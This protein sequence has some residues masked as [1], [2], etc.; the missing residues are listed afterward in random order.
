MDGQADSTSFVCD[1]TGNGLAN[2][3]DGVGAEVV[4]ALPL[5][6]LDRVQQADVT[7]RDQILQQ[8][9]AVCVAARHADHKT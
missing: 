4:T 7:F 5:K 6:L 2:P 1:G 9:A 8:Q 3:P